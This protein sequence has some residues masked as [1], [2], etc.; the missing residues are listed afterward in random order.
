[1][2]QV[3]EREG[4]REESDEVMIKSRV[5]LS[6]L[7][8]LHPFLTLLCCSVCCFLVLSYDNDMCFVTLLPS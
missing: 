2:M 3:V 8:Y 1:M 5:S 4:D 7:L 6:V